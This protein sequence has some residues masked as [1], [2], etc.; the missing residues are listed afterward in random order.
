MK[1][2]TVEPFFG[3][4]SPASTGAGAELPKLGRRSDIAWQATGHADDGDRH[5]LFG[6]LFRGVGEPVGASGITVR[7][8]SSAMTIVPVAMTIG[9]PIGMAF[10]VGMAVGVPVSM[11]VSITVGRSVGMAVA[12]SI[13][14]SSIRAVGTNAGVDFGAVGEVAM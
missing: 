6:G 9:E 2:V 14:L 10:T 13:R 12:A 4:L 1:D 11:P 3:D 8:S 7:R 5:R